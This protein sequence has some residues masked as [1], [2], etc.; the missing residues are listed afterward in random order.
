[1]TIRLHK[2]ALKGKFVALLGYKMEIGKNIKRIREAK[3]LSQK[4]V[5]T[6]IDMG[7]AKSY[8]YCGR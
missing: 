1:M 8:F 6:A 5:I 7:A 3:S 4:D 2:T